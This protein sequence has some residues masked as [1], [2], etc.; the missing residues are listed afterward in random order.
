MLAKETGITVLVVNIAY[1][2][3]KMWPLLRHQLFNSISGID[4]RWAKAK[5]SGTELR[6]FITRISLTLLFL[7]IF[8]AGRIAIGGSLPKFSQ[9]DNPAAYHPCIFTRFLTF[10]YL[11]AFNW[12]LMICP[13]TLSHD[14]QMSSIPLITAWSDARNLL[15]VMIVLLLL[16][17]LYRCLADF[18]VRKR[19][20]KLAKQ[21]FKGH[22]VAETYNFNFIIYL[23]RTARATH[24]FSWVYLC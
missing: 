21:K 2:G 18:K 14:W 7:G 17:L 10:S 6:Q 4:V 22:F 5:R 9:Q 16:G 13:T 15:T 1:D 11:A 23:F 12:W 3:Y 8:C 19:V 24:R 20:N